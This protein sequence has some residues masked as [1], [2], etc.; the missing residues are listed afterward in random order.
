M[1]E[2]VAYVLTASELL[3]IKQKY[4]HIKPYPKPKIVS[5]FTKWDKYSN[6]CINGA[7]VRTAKVS[8]YCKIC[9]DRLR[10]EGLI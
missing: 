7:C 6:Y 5:G 1:G 9:E 10:K 4:L 2:V 8:G 3:L